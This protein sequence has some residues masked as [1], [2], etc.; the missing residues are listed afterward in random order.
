[1]SSAIHLNYGKSRLTADLGGN[2]KVKMFVPQRTKPLDAANEMLKAIQDPVDSPP[3]G[4]LADLAD[5]VTIC[6]PDR[7]RP[8]IARHL[9]PSVIAILEGAGIDP[10]NIT[11]LIANG[12]HSSHNENE[13]IEI[14]GDEI[15]SK[16]GIRE[17]I[18]RNE[19]DFVRIGET[20]RGTPVALNRS[21][22]DTDLV[23]LISTVTTHYFAGWGGGRKMILPGVA[24][25][26][27]IWAN[28]RLTLTPNGDLNE[29]CSSGRLEGNPVHEDMLEAASM[30]KNVFSI[31]VVLNGYGEP[32]DVT[33]GDLRRSHEI[34]VEKAFDILKVRVF[35]PCRLAIA[36]A[37]G[38]PFDIDFIQSHKSI[39]H[40]AKCVSDG[41]VIIMVAECSRGAGSD[42]FLPWFEVGD[43][44]DVASKL[45]QNY[46][47]N[48]HTALAL[49]KKLERL[50]II[51]VSSLPQTV[52]EKMGMF[53]A[54]SLNEAL[55]VAGKIFN[56]AETTYVFPFAWGI[57][58]LIS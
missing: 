36:S 9:L 31:N 13:V 7:T 46:E 15:A 17:N 6:V 43:A 30:V 57:L 20:S 37:G 19:Q 22:V 45:K 32:A 18:S 12:S 26:E 58:P 35:E 44:S 48:G 2:L 4:E 8:R 25:L 53:P 34:A 42:T 55:K 27:T 16:I 21:I 51:L 14:V 10:Q 11:L 56:G 49:M 52:V 24:S 47:L 50:S 38:Y 39:D 41:G 1:M 40:V 54:S 28:H 33:C 29:S 23:I 5:R 3:L